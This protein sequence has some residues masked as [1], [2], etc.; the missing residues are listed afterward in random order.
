MPVP[1]PDK[2]RS[3]H[4][5]GAERD[6]VTDTVLAFTLDESAIRNVPG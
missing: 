4:S 2:L 3:P 1:D 6:S 5:L